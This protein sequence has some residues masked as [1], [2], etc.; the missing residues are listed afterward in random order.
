MWLDKLKEMKNERGL[1]T[2]EISEKSGIPEPTLEK[3][4]SGATKDPKLATMQQLVHFLG[5]TLDDLSDEQKPN[6]TFSRDEQTHIKKYR[7]LDPYGKEAVD[8]ILEIEHKRC[9]AAKVFQPVED[10]APQ[11][12]YI[13][14]YLVPAAAGYASPIE[15]EDY[16]EIPLPPGAPANADYCITVSGDSMAPYIKDGELV[17]VKQGAPLR[18]FEPGIFFV[19]GDVFCKQWCPGYAGETYLLSANPKREDANITIWKDSG[20][21]CVYFGKVL[22][23]KKLPRPSYI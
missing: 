20:R 6:E 3:L 1:T 22:L 9:T 19:D 23:D 18:E 15:G 7:S 8:S 4:F 10:T 14:H 11:P 17:Y 12:V 2:K 21:N 5:F 16:E 13:K